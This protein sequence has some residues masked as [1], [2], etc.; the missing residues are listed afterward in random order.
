MLS[1]APGPVIHVECLFVL[2]QTTELLPRTALSSLTTFAVLRKHTWEGT[3]AVVSARQSVQTAAC[4][5]FRFAFLPHC[6]TQCTA[7]MS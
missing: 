4:L 5:T 2:T 3:H 1:L 7:V 6:Q